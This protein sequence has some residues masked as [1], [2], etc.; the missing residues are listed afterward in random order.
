MARKWLHM[1]GVLIGAIGAITLCALSGSVAGAFARDYT[2]PAETNAPAQG[3]IGRAQLP[4][5]AVNTL[6]L[7][8]AGPSARLLPRIHRSHASRT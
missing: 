7:I 1:K 8:A 6:N 2:A 5:E 4:R 3:T